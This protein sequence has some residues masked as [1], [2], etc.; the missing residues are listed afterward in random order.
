MNVPTYGHCSKPPEPLGRSARAWRR[1]L[2]GLRPPAGTRRA[3]AG[4][5]GLLAAQH[6]RADRTEADLRTEREA[7][8]AVQ[9]ELVAE[10]EARAKAEGKAEALQDRLGIAEEAA[11]VLRL[12]EAERRGRGRLPRLLAAWRGE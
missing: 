11:E 6:E 10:K 12:V 1:W 9:G 7:Q 2:L 5:T 3:C 4:L 8:E